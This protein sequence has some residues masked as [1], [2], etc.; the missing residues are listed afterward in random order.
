LGNLRRAEAAYSEAATVFETICDEESRSIALYLLGH[1]TL[2]MA[3]LHKREQSDGQ[4]NVS[5]IGSEAKAY[6]CEALA[7]LEISL[8]IAGRLEM[9]EILEEITALLGQAKSLLLIQSG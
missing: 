5:V 2:A 1:T 4:F 8:E 9:G 7:S 6:A 3:R